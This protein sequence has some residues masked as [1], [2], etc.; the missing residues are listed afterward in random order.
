MYISTIYSP[1]LWRQRHLS[2][3]YHVWEAVSGP[4]KQ[5]SRLYFADMTTGM[6][7]EPTILSRNSVPTSSLKVEE[8]QVPFV[9]EDDHLLRKALAG[10]SRSFASLCDRYRNR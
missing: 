10:D 2:C 1:M 9:A 8:A 4:G 6:S 5:E 7:D 3:I